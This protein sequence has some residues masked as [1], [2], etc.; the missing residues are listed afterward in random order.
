MENKLRRKFIILSMG[1]V[2]IVFF[3]ICVVVGTTVYKSVNLKNDIIVELLSKNEGKFPRI[4]ELVLSKLSKEVPYATRYFSALVDENNESLIIDISNISTIL[5][6]DV[7]NYI[8]L[9]FSEER[10]E[11]YIDNFQFLVTQKRNGD[12]L[13]VFV[14]RS[15]E[16]AL[17]NNFYSTSIYICGTAFVSIFILIFALSKRA[18]SPIVESYEKQQQ[19]ITDVSHELKTP[20]AIIKTNNDVIELISGETDWTKSINNQVIK[21]DGLVNNLIVLTKMDEKNHELLKIK[22]SLSDAISESIEPFKM[23]ADNNQKTFDLNIQKNVSYS[24]DEASIRR[25]IS[26]LLDNALKYAS[27]NST[28]SIHFKKYADKKILKI[29]NFSEH[30]ET[31]KYNELFERF[32]RADSSR[33]SETGGHGIGLSIAKSILENHRGKIKAE[34]TDGKKIVFTIEF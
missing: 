31:K 34:S 14:D 11:G 23:I 32:Y 12:K 27:P 20:L 1:S 15:T 8:N 17:L 21:L 6:E 22:F 16:I 25:V 28:I 3:I 18:I 30:L 19:F 7:I 26:I 29:S 4:E 9:I 5:R 13:L 24:G 10:Y 2:F 33:N